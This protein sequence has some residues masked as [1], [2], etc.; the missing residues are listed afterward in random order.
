MLTKDSQVNILLKEAYYCLGMSKM[1]IKDERPEA[2]NV[3]KLAE[4]YEYI[5]RA[6]ATRF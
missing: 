6:A 3:L 2:Y 5:G 4:F 1:T